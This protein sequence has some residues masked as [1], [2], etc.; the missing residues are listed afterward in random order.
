MNGCA[1]VGPV[2]G[3]Y[4]TRVVTNYEPPGRPNCCG[5]IAAGRR[6]VGIKP[7]S[8]QPVC[9]RMSTEVLQCVFGQVYFPS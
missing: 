4:P 7:A 8:A 3:S 5:A 1:G 2:A 6:I 9:D